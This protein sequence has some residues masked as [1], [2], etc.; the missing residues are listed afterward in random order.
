MALRQGERCCLDRIFQFVAPWRGTLHGCIVIIDGAALFCARS[1]VKPTDKEPTNHPSV[2]RASWH[3][4]P[5]LNWHLFSHRWPALGVS[6]WYVAVLQLRFVVADA[7]LSNGLCN[8]TWCLATKT[9]TGCKRQSMVFWIPNYS[10]F[11]HIHLLQRLTHAARSDVLTGSICRWNLQMPWFRTRAPVT[12]GRNP[13]LDDHHKK[14]SADSEN[15]QKNDDVATSLRSL[16]PPSGA[17]EQWRQESL[18][19]NTAPVPGAAGISGTPLRTAAKAALASAL[20]S[21]GDHPMLRGAPRTPTGPEERSRFPFYCPLCMCYFS[22]VYE[23]TCCKHLVCVACAF[24]Y[25]TGTGCSV[26]PV[27][28]FARLPAACAWFNQPE[29]WRSA[30][31]FF[32]QLVQCLVKFARV[33]RPK[34][35]ASCRL[36]VY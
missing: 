9:T 18:Q 29:A 4:A 32:L 20:A 12:P 5:V 3:Q 13:H 24:D 21:H 16:P 28:M 1:I 25:L 17:T 2:N 8:H 22:A 36:F 27:R 35:R 34:V 7:R 11:F 31:R 15:E 19:V 26:V 30:R 10:E 23:L 6:V 14:S 33:C